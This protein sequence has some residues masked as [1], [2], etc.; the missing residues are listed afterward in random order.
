MEDQEIPDPGKSPYLT[1][2]M[3]TLIR[4]VKDEVL[5]DLSNIKSGV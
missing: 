1:E 3:F 5:L 4:V 2:D